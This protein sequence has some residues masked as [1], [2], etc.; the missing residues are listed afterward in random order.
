VTEALLIEQLARMRSAPSSLLIAGNRTGAAAL[1]S[2]FRYPNCRIVC[3][4]FDLHHIR[5]ILRNLSANGLAAALLHDP[6]V[7]PPSDLPVQAKR[8]SPRL[9]CT[10]SI[11][12]GPY[13][14]A[15][16]MSTPGT[17]PGELILDQLEDIHA[18][19]AIGGR[20]IMACEAESGPLFKQLKVIFGNLSV[21]FDQKGVFCATSIKR[22]PLAK[23][24]NF[25]A[26]FEASLPGGTPFTLCSLPGVFCHRRPDNG[27]LALAEVASR[28][29]TPDSRILDLGCGCGLVGLLLAHQTS[30]A[31]V[32]FVDSHARAL[33]ATHLNL[34]A[35]GLEGHD[36]RLSDTG[37]SQSGYDLF[38]GNPPYYSDF[39]I[40]QLFIVTAY[41]ALR[42]AG[43]CLLVAKAAHKLQALQAE[44]FANAEILPRRG[45]G[46][47]RSL[48]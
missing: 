44:R 2:S 13:D 23:R 30:G 35:M 6:F 29:L 11:P 3:H 20:C 25:Q 28:D 46:V 48:R 12:E 16:F 41:R 19:L 42:P 17:M 8:E 32:S 33:A 27:G 9:A 40:A 38:V 7:T 14:T 36:L 18:N 5:S 45:Y 15:L 26:S 22:A 39:R 10:S 47:V 31:R 1:V 37:T 24:R 4:A 34:T 21:H 43:A